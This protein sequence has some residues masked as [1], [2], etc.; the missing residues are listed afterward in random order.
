MNLLNRN[1]L[2][3]FF[4]LTSSVVTAAALVFVEIHNG[5]SLYGYTLWSYFPVGAIGAGMLVAIGFYITARWVRLRPAP[6]ML[7]AILAI[8]AVSVFVMDSM[9]CGLVAEGRG[10]IS[11]ASSV[12]PF[13]SYSLSQTPLKFWPSGSFSGDDSSTASAPAPS[14]SAAASFSGD[15]NSSV[16]G[17]GGG[18][19]GMLATGNALS[20]DNISHSLGG[21]RQRIA[22]LEAFGAGAMNHGAAL[23]FAVLHFIGFALA[24][25]L[26]YTQL[27]TLSY[28]DVCMLFLKRKGVQTRYFD[29]SRGMQGAVDAFLTMVKGRQY[30]QSIEVHSGEGSAAKSRTSAF[31]ST[32]EVSRCKGCPKHRL[33]FSARR[34][35]GMA[36]KDIDMLGYTTFCLEPINIG[37]S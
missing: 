18:V 22:G 2:V 9:E 27:R 14:A 19:Q 23:V 31:S 4:V 28:C 36:W 8:S 10:A 34:K 16:S 30:R 33:K 37:R 1:L 6:I 5:H 3:M 29:S 25:I 24:G 13:L 11:D 21:A 35:D 32:V 20:A 7:L 17:I 15:S 26:A 12:A